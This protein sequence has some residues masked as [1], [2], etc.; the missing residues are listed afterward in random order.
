MCDTVSFVPAMWSSVVKII[1][2]ASLAVPCWLLWS[3]GFLRSRQAFNNNSNIKYL[4]QIEAKDSS[5]V[6]YKSTEE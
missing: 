3:L 4:S 1:K 6:L 5:L 2:D